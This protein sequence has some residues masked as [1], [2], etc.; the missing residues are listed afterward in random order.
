MTAPF[1]H[2]YEVSLDAEGSGGRVQ[3]PPR[4]SLLGG[5]PPEFDGRDDWWSPEALLLGAVGL[6]VQ[7]T[8]QA[9][10]RRQELPMLSWHARCDGVVDKTPIGLAFTSIRVEAEVVVS[11]ADVARAEEL[12]TRVARHCLVSN[13]LKTPVNVSIHVRSV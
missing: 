4:P 13:S 11:G 10:A 12:A 9:L 6:C 1:P 2:H 7:T 8:Y 3:A 5:P